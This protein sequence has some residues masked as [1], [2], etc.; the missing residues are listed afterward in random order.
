MKFLQ[1]TL[2]H[3]G[4]W[5]NMYIGS[6]ISLWAVE[7]DC[8]ILRPKKNNGKMLKTQEILL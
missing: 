1:Q 8:Y 3:L 2:L 6:S 7:V 4:L 5:F